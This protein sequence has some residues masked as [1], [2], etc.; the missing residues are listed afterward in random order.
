[1]HKL[2]QDPL[3]RHVIFF[4]ALK[5][6]LLAML[7]WFVVREYRSDFGSTEVGQALLP[8]VPPVVETLKDPAP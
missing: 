4:V 2:W 1:M 5:F 8:T 7:W 6:V 3:N